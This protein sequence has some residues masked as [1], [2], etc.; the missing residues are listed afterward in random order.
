MLGKTRGLAGLIQGAL[1]VIGVLASTSASRAQSN[2][3]ESTVDD[4]ARAVWARDGGVYESGIPS[5]IWNLP[6]GRI[7][8]GPNT[9]TQQEVFAN[10]EAIS[11][12]VSNPAATAQSSEQ[13]VP[14]VGLSQQDAERAVG[15]ALPAAII[16][17]L[18]GFLVFK[19]ISS[20]GPV[21]RERKHLAWASLTAIPAY[22]RLLNDAVQGRL[23][24]GS[25]GPLVGLGFWPVFFIT[26]VLLY[27]SLKK[28]G[29]SRDGIARA[30]NQGGDKA[31][32]EAGSANAQSV[33]APIK[34]VTQPA[35]TPSARPVVV[36][37]EQRK[38]LVIALF[39]I[40]AVLFLVFIRLGS[41]MDYSHSMMLLPISE[42]PN[43]SAFLR[44]E[45]ATYSWGILARSGP[46]GVV[47]G[48]VVPVTLIFTALFIRRAN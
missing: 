43:P 19:A 9:W 47:L 32:L 24:E 27:W 48:L 33:S 26:G 3:V 31:A 8:P 37:S 45:R 13:S 12:T 42:V 15:A 35:L 16:A 34:S 14:T 21:S 20:E 30:I 28:R 38:I 7:I 2:D 23:G 25:V 36:N 22:M 1:L 46:L 11:P 4:T 44:L 29:R 10:A 17:G 39:A 6:D 18:L 41:A 5:G 40:S